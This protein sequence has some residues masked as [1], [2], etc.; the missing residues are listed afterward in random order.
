[1]SIVPNSSVK[2]SMIGAK[3][4]QCTQLVVRI[5]QHFRELQRF[6][7][8]SQGLRHGP[9]RVNQRGTKRRVRAP[10]GYSLMRSTGYEPQ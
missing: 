10:V 6:G 1:M 7:P 3:A 8:A 2:L 4:T 5:A 9:G